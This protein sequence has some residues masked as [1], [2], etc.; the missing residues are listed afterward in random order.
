MATKCTHLAGVLG[1]AV[2]EGPLGRSDSVETTAEVHLDAGA[3]GDGIAGRTA[4]VVGSLRRHQTVRAAAVTRA[5]TPSHYQQVVCNR[6][7]LSSIHSK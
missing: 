1:A 6:T 2:E 3:A 7:R 5:S 4:E